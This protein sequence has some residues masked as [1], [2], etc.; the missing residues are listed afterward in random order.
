M[1]ISLNKAKTIII[2]DGS[3]KSQ[4][5]SVFYSAIKKD[6]SN[7]Q[8]YSDSLTNRLPDCEST[9]EFLI[10][11]YQI[12][13]DDYSDDAIKRYAV[14]TKNKRKHS[15]SRIQYSLD[16]ETLSFFNELNFYFHNYFF[17]KVNAQQDKVIAQ[18]EKEI[19]K[20]KKELKQI[21]GQ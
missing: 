6:K 14:K 8:Q 20:L 5:L 1:D 13:I 12:F 9:Y 7:F 19:A 18:K 2:K 11:I 15:E 16:D 10:Y 3:S 17:Y 21:Q 4:L